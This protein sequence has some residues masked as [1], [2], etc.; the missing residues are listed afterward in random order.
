LIDIDPQSGFLMVLIFLQ[1]HEKLHLPI[2]NHHP[3]RRFFLRRV[4][5]GFYGPRGV[6]AAPPWHFWIFL[7][8]IGSE[9]MATP[10]LMHLLRF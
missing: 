1:L 3:I 8:F 6:G 7:W 4:L 9:I 5:R 10:F 2:S